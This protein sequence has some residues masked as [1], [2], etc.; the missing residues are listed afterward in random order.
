MMQRNSGMMRFLEAKGKLPKMA[1]GGSVRHYDD[2]G[3]VDSPT[4]GELAEQQETQDDNDQAVARIRS[5]VD[6]E[7]DKDSRVNKVAQ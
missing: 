3:E 5:Q 1:R 7:K 4:T 6:R 2:G